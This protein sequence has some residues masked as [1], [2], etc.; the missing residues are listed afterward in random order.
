MACAWALAGCGNPL[1]IPVAGLSYGAIE[2]LGASQPP[3]AARD[4]QFKVK[5]LYLTGWTAGRADRVEHYAALAD[6]SE[7]NAYVVDVKDSDGYVGYDSKVPEVAQ[8]KAWKRKFHPEKALP[9]FHDHHVRVI[10]RIVCFKDP[11]L[12]AAKPEWA[13]QNQAGGVWKDDKKVAWLNPYKKEC[14]AYSVALA[15]EAVALGFD[16]IQ[17]DY[18]RFPSDGNT[19]AMAFGDTGGK[20][21]A[22]IVAEFLA[23]ARKQIPRVTLSADVFG[24]ICESP[25]DSENIGQWLEKLGNDVDYLCPMVYPSHYAP[26]QVVNGVCYA[27]PDLDPYGVVHNTLVKAKRRIGTV[28]NYKA[29]IRPYLQDFTATWLGSGRYQKYGAE[30][31]RQQ[32]KAVYDAGYDEWILWSANNT[33]SESALENEPAPAKLASVSGPKR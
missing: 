5:A 30:Q 7:I 31:V 18:I 15:N 4:P 2:R 25:E 21:R 24:I 26:G 22:E 27:R 16:E 6:T 17:F 11:V 29:H 3:A 14:W 32:I 28:D 12:A 1:W 10:A 20:S 13:I 9:V 19:K 33:Y 8:A 23:Y